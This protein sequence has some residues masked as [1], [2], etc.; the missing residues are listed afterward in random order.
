MN[1]PRLTCPLRRRVGHDHQLPQFRKLQQW[2]RQQ[3][4]Q[5]V[6][7]TTITGRTVMVDT[8][9]AEAGSGRLQPS[10]NCSMQGKRWPVRCLMM[11][12]SLGRASVAMRPQS[13]L[14][15]LLVHSAEPGW[16]NM[17]IAELFSPPP[18]RVT[19]ATSA[20]PSFT[21]LVS[22]SIFDL[23]ADVHGKGWTFLRA[24]HRCAAR[25]Q[26]Y[27]EQPYSVVGSHPSQ[28]TC[29]RQRWS[30]R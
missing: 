19:L 28:E 25:R 16:A 5:T 12:S 14:D 20:L 15:L 9:D 26:L 17:K 21:A 10:T 29:A 3:S 2:I 22:G 1:R 4:L 6:H 24:D 13:C 7:V 27:Q 18:P 23:R 30:K 8:D 11:C